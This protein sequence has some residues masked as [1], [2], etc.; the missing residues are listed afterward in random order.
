MKTFELDCR[1]ITILKRALQS[2]I[3]ELHTV[4]ATTVDDNH[5]EM[6]VNRIMETQSIRAKMLQSYEEVA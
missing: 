6:L 3:D 5:K 4:L 1:E 2:R